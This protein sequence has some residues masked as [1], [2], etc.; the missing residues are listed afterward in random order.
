MKAVELQCSSFAY[1]SLS[2]LGPLFH[3]TWGTVS[4]PSALRGVRVHFSLHWVSRTLDAEEVSIKLAR[5]V[6]IALF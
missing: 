3:K 1:K 2:T 6:A 4:G 5:H